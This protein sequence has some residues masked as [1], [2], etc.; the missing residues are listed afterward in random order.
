MSEYRRVLSLVTE[1]LRCVGAE[2]PDK[3]VTGFLRENFD[4]RFALAVD[5]DLRGG[6]SRHWAESPGVIQVNPGEFHAYVVRHPLARVY[7]RTGAAVPLRLSDVAAPG[8]RPAVEGIA[9]ARVLAIPLTVSPAHIRAI[10]LVRG[11]ADFTDHDVWLACQLQPILGGIDALRARLGAAGA[12]QR[13]PAPAAA[14]GPLPAAAGAGE[15]LTARE[16]A[17]LDL[18]AGGLITGAI[19]RQLR[20]SPRTVSKHVESIYRK[21]GTHD[22]AS[23]ILRGQALGL[24]R[25][26][27]GHA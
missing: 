14:H 24:L 11:G 23:A 19:A 6:G 15:C 17:V 27:S 26:P 9:E 25:P 2:F 4:A 18:M 12:C 5:A 10:A 16:A 21:F 8:A 20:I 1:M 13:P 7:G 22:R 3:A